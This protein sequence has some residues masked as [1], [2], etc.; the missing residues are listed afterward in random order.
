MLVG[1]GLCLT[2]AECN[3]V[4]Q[5]PLSS[6][7]CG[8]TLNELRKGCTVKTDQSLK[9]IMLQTYSCECGSTVPDLNKKNSMKQCLPSSAVG[10]TRK[11]A[12]RFFVIFFSWVCFY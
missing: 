5:P 6:W 12:E 3:Q 10:N 1:K 9:S 8:L 7:S 4:H 11:C 2:R